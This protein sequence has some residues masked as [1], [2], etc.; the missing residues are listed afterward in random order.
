MERI[1]VTAMTKEKHIIGKDNWLPWNIPEELKMFRKLTEN[2]TI[3]MGRKTYDSIGRPMPKRHN[4]VVSR[5]VTTV[6][7]D[8]VQVCQNVEDA[9]HE[10]RRL[11]KPIYIIGGAQIYKH[12]LQN[13]LVD[14][15]FVSFIKKEYDGDTVFPEFDEND[16]DVITNVDY[17][18][19]E[20]VIMQ[21]K[22]TKDK[23]EKECKEKE[24]ANEND[25][26]TTD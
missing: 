13:N 11:S 23:E 26:N 1:I 8:A 15:M 16:W 2:G 24:E 12:A 17:E 5:T 18:E 10:A 7:N 25:N 6:G 9:I 20:F 4:I 14:K 21:K 22:G 19:F 3:I